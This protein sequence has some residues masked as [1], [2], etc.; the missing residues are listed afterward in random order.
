MA[1]RGSSKC[2]ARSYPERSQT[3]NLNKGISLGKEE[4]EEENV[5]RR[6][7][8]LIDNDVCI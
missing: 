1:R 8:G 2:S 4:N 3:K 7:V 6:T 5:S